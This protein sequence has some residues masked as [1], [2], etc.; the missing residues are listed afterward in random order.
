MNSKI[1]LPILLISAVLVLVTPTI[2]GLINSKDDVIL[3]ETKDYIYVKKYKESIIVNSKSFN[4][5]IKDSTIYRYKQN[6]IL[7]DGIIIYATHK[8]K[9]MV[10]I[11]T[12]KYITKN[13]KKYKQTSIKQIND[14]FTCA[15]VDK[16][17]DKLNKR[18]IVTK[19]YYPKERIF[20]KTLD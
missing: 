2:Y 9:H 1:F 6:K 4:I 13:N 12:I 11:K 15:Q 19:T 10:M 14:I 16:L 7:Y 20:Y 18:I 5:H 8:P 17:K 3:K